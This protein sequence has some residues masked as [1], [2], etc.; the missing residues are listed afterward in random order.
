L[1]PACLAGALLAL[2]MPA[3]AGEVYQ[4]KDAKGVTHYS[5]APPPNQ[6]HKTRS[7]S[8]N[9]ASTVPAADKPVPANSDCSKA[10]SNLTILQGTTAVGIDLDNDGKSDRN[11]TAEERAKRLVLAEASIKT[12]CEVALADEP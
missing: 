2:A 9:G 11:L 7:I 4:W 6:K 8:V 12:Y 5:D 1:V 10:R 3:L